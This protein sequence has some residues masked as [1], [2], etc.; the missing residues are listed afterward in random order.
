MTKNFKVFFI[1]C[2]FVIL[3]SC[4]CV[5][6]QKFDPFFCMKQQAEKPFRLVRK[7]VDVDYSVELNNI[8]GWRQLPDASIDFYLKY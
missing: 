2:A 6:E 8:G 3:S 1:T 4:S 7:V 5:T